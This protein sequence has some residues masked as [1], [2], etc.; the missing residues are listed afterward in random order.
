MNLISLRKR[1]QADSLYDFVICA[2]ELLASDDESRRRELEDRLLAM[3]PKL[4]QTPLF[5]VL[6]V[7]DPALRAMLDDSDNAPPLPARLA[8][9]NHPAYRAY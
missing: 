5:D 3:L 7:R 8:A 6:V 4:R 1:Q 2:A 9:S